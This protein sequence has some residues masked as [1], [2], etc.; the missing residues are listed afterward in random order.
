MQITLALAK[1]QQLLLLNQ[2]DPHKVG[3]HSRVSSADPARVQGIIEVTP[4]GLFGLLSSASCGAFALT[5]DQ[6]VVFWNH[7]AREILGYTP[8][9]VVGRHCS[10][11]ACGLG[12][13]TLT[14]DCEEGCMMVR[15]LRAGLVPGRARMRMRCA[16]GKLKDLVVTPMVVSGVE[17]GGP[18]L[19]YL[20]GDSGE[21]AVSADVKRLV[22][23]GGGAVG[24]WLTE[25]PYYARPGRFLEEPR[26]EDIRAGIYGSD[27]Y[28]PRLQMQASAGPGPRGKDSDSDN[29]D[30][31][32]RS[33]EPGPDEVSLTDREREV[34]SYLALGWETRYIAEELGVSRYTARN[35]IENL[36]RKLGASSRLEAVMLAMRLGII[37]S[38]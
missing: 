13:A 6:T 24:S 21:A 33:A 15:S 27:D 23:L 25:R 22:E 2:V 9:R 34:L 11:I 4:D 10:G 26:E 14:D 19:V 29:D 16:S 35:H 30:L 7:R 12:E 37:P 31:V 38:Q 20:F 3:R 36:R 8:A 5:T 18:L 17:D 1:Q 28:D 32:R